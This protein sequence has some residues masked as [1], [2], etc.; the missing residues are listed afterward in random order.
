M[1]FWA[2]FARWSIYFV[3]ASFF[4]HWL[5]MVVQLVVRMTG[6][7]GT[8]FGIGAQPFEPYPVYGL[9]VFGMVAL[10]DSKAFGK[11]LFVEQAA[12]EAQHPKTLI[13]K[14]GQN[15]FGSVLA[16]FAF[17]TGI[18]AI[19]EYLVGWLS[20]LRWGQNP[21][22]NYADKPFNLH[23]LICL[24]N[25]L[26]FGVAATAFMLLVFPWTEKLLNKLPEKALYITAGGLW[27]VFW[28]C[29]IMFGTR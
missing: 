6:G 16:V 23:G 15:K 27:A 1:K 18:C 20:V 8:S 17:L 28:A 22:W 5:E 11:S 21:F 9:A 3:A 12:G 14:T 24:Q 4:G 7:E 10:W 29:Q 25:A 26:L 19:A 13:K 2:K